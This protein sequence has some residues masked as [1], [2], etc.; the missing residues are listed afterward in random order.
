MPGTILVHCKDFSEYLFE[1]MS[2]SRVVGVYMT[3][4]GTALKN[5]D[6]F[7]GANSLVQRV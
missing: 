5:H 6:P 7:K 2:K 1:Q 3:D 4:S